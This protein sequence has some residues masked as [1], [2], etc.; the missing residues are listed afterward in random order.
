MSRRIA[1]FSDGTGQSVGRN[2]SN[3]LRLCKMLDLADPE[4][5]RE[6]LRR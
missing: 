4:R 5:L 6:L 3:V 2:D 1:I